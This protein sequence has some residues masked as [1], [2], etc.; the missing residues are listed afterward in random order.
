VD[1]VGDAD[2]HGSSPEGDGELSLPA[3]AV[4]V[5][6][7]APPVVAAESDSLSLSA[8]EAEAPPGL[9][10]PEGDASPTDETTL[11]P[12]MEV[13]APLP[14]PAHEETDDSPP[15]VPPV[16]EAS[17]ADDEATSHSGGG[18]S[19]HDELDSPDAEQSQ[20]DDAPAGLSE[21]V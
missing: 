16:G 18:Q 7:E 4:T 17:G 11:S 3:L 12:P 13:A 9:D 8:V 1:S 20:G 15:D 14:A 5:V 2:G 6:E 10:V 19:P 21:G